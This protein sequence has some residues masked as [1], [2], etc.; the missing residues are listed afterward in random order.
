[1][2]DYSDFYIDAG[3]CRLRRLFYSDSMAM[4]KLANDFNI[5]INVRDYFP[6]PYT[7]ENALEFIHFCEAQPVPYNFA[8]EYEGQLCGVIGIIP[9]EDVYHRTADFGYWVGQPFQGKGIA[10]AAAVALCAWLFREYK[11]LRLQAGVFEWN[12]ASMR[13]LEK[14]GFQLEGIARKNVTKNGIVCDEYRYGLVN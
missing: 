1:M 13:V 12:K 10:T 8:I 14:S 6:H 11:F 4:T 3:I 5:W 9:Q 7:Y 2:S